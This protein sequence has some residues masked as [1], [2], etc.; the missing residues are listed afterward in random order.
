MLQKSPSHI[1]LEV[2]YR[3]IRGNFNL[4]L[5]TGGRSR[6]PV[7]VGIVQELMADKEDANRPIA[8]AYVQVAL[9]FPRYGNGTGLGFIGFNA[10]SLQCS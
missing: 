1:F 6:R 2:G 8:S 5:V 7:A 3:F 4:L 10:A 9:L